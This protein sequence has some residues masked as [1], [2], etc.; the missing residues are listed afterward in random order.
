MDYFIAACANKRARLRS[1]CVILDVYFDSNRF[2]CGAFEMFLLFF[3]FLLKKF[4]TVEIRV[5]LYLLMGLDF[6]S[7]NEW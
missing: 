4:Q 1:G 3:W 7:E 6:S 2:V 5:V